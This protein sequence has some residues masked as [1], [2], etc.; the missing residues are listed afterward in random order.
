MKQHKHIGVYALVVH[1]DSI[2]LIKKARGPY[3]GKLDL[4]GGSL[5][6]SENP[7][8]GLKR[9]LQEETG[10]SIKNQKLI[11]FLTHTVIYKD[12]NE[13]IQMYHLGIIYEVEISDTDTLKYTGDGEDSNGAIWVKIAEIDYKNLSPFAKILINN[14]NKPPLEKS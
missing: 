6:F 10:L 12:N 3:T 5:E 8:D 14:F 7:L 4:P 1:N 9:E 11:D 2:L 13:E